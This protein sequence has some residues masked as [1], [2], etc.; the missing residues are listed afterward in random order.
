MVHEV[1]AHTWTVETSQAGPKEQCWNLRCVGLFVAWFSFH[2]CFL[3][4]TQ[5][6]IFFQMLNLNTI[7]H[8][9]T[10]LGISPTIFP[11]YY[12]KSHI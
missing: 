12:L 10:R 4:V 2:L 3:S 5:T 9:T 11:F 8:K 7:E 6:T 1:W